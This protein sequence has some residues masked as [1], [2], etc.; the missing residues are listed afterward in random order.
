MLEKISYNIAIA[1]ESIRQNKTRSLLTSLGIIFGVASVIAMLAIG[2]GAQQEI[3]EQI[4]LL[5]ANNVI[6]T[7]IVEQEESRVD[8]ADDPMAEKRPFSPGLT[9]ADAQNIAAAVPGVVDV[10]P[11]V[12]LETT[13]LRAGLRRSTK[14]VGVDASYFTYSDFEL[15]EGNFFTEKQL[16]DAKPVCIIGHKAKT[17]FF[18]KDEAIGMQIKAGSLWLTVVGVLEERSI[19]GEHLEHLGLRDYNLDIYT[20]RS[21][22]VSR[23]GRP[24]PNGTSG[25]PPKMTTGG[26]SARITTSSTGWSCTRRRASTCRPSRTWLPA[27]W[28]AATSAWSTTR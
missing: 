21:C 11:E 24:S 23:T 17:R 14:L 27:C 20:R 18:P 5:G 6:V 7:P 1:V 9:L 8:E 25:E 3:L 4:R 19:S 13:A 12:V 10:S 22:C 16:A 15:A 28:P 26:A 2:N